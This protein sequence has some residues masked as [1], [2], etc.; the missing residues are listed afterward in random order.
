MDARKYLLA[1][2]ATLILSTGVVQS[3][4]SDE[5]KGRLCKVAFPNS[6]AAE[7]QGLFLRAVAM[8]HS[9][10]ATEVEIQRLAVAGWIAFAR[11]T[12]YLAQR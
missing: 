4:E 5:A 2:C 11:A 8:L 10:R 6:C 3:H 9:F 7:V 12:V 1:V